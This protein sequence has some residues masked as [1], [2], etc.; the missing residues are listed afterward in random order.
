MTQQPGTQLLISLRPATVAD[1]E[2]AKSLYLETT[3]KL[4]RALGPVE[5]KAVIE[6]FTRAFHR[7][8]AQVI[9]RDG[10]DIGWIQVSETDGGLHLHQLHLVGRCRNQGIGTKLI[11]DLMQRAFRK[12]APVSLNV[13]RGNPAISLYRRLGF[14]VV[15]EDEEKLQMRCDPG[16]V[17]SGG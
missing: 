5:D 3:V 6:R 15:G 12:G 2:F 4:L 10:S 7:N 1:F 8:P 9:R 13:V 17:P 11:R 14:R 16:L